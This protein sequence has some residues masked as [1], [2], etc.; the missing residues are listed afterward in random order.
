MYTVYFNDQDSIGIDATTLAE[1]IWV[2]KRFSLL[3]E[4][5]RIVGRV[6]PKFDERVSVITWSEEDDEA[7]D[8]LYNPRLIG[9]C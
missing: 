2:G 8:Q 1:A 4:T 9:R 7:P 6:G 3:T 5:P